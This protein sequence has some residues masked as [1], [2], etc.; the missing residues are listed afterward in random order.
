MGD[1]AQRQDHPQSLHGHDLGGEIPVAEIDFGSGGLVARW[2]A[3]HGVG[4]AAVA[5][6]QSIVGAR[7]EPA[8]GQA[9]GGEGRVEQVAGGIAGERPPSPVRTMQTRRKPDDQHTGVQAAERR[10]GRVVMA[11]K[12]LD[13]LG[14]ER[15]QPR[16][17]GAVGRG[18][19]WAQPGRTPARGRPITSASSAGSLSIVRD[20]AWRAM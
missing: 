6:R 16:T 20:G 10:H 8:G 3:T 1:R 18:C 12:A 7:L 13:V 14:A 17:A 5:R 19:L 11:G 2:H 15:H 4:D 9:V